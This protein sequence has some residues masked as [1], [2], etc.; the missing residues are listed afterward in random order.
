MI[1]VRPPTGA[2]KQCFR[3]RVKIGPEAH[4]ASC[5]LCSGGYSAQG[6]MR[7]G[8]EADNLPPSGVEVKNAWSCTSTPHTSS[9]YCA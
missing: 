6:L 4:T 1:E 5:Q 2:G 7:Q 8:R 9:R 3:Q